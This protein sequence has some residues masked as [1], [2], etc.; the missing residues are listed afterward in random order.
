MPDCHGSRTQLTH[1]PIRW[2][3]SF[4]LRLLTPSHMRA[5]IPHEGAMADL[6]W[7]DPD[8]EKEDFAISPRYVDVTQFIQRSSWSRS[9]RN[10]NPGN[11]NG[12]V[13]LDQR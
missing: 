5:E 10:Y 7:S 9:L 2:S 8:S 6:V 3:L 13:F 4:T 1:P 12:D 11:L